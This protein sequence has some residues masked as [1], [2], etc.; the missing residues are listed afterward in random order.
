MPNGQRRTGLAFQKKDGY[1]AVLKIFMD[2]TG[3]HDDAD[4]VAVA[5]YISRPKYWRAWTKDWNKAKKPI[6]VFHATDCATFHG[7]FDGWTKERRDP[8]VAN[9]LPIIPAHEMAGVVIGVQ[10][11]DLA[12]EMKECAELIEMFGTP[13]TAC[14]QWAISIIMEIATERGSGERMAFVHEVND[15]K[16]EALK[17]FSYVNE[18]LNPRSIPMT[19]GF[20]NKAD[21]PPLQA[22]DVLAYEGG[23]F[24]K[25][26]MGTPRRAWTALD[27]DKTRI[28]ARRYAKDNMPT[29]ISLL[30]G[31]R[32]RLLSQ[33]WDGKVEK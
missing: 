11:K 22:A 27:P 13:Y 3:V 9:L 31:F 2:E 28:I 10:L 14:F 21:F 18:F 8:Y 19:M 7:E 1:V 15:Y 20:G 23:K 32:A 25:N 30:A 33:G 4:M 5:A 26:P 12:A 17:A 6:K 24:L 16:G 29:L